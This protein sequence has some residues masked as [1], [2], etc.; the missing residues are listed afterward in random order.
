MARSS[1]LETKQKTVARV[2]AITTC[3]HPPEKYKME[4]KKAIS[5]IHK[6][7]K[8]NKGGGGLRARRPELLAK[9]SHRSHTHTQKRRKIKGKTI[10]VE[11]A[12]CWSSEP[13]K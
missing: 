2:S 9:E 4:R 11:S 10:D 1:T 5:G 6:R 8:Q 7:N 12:E 3:L 13:G